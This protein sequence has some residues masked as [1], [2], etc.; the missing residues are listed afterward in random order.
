MHRSIWAVKRAHWRCWTVGRR[1]LR[2]ARVTPARFDLLQC[3]WSRGGTMMQRALQEALCVVRSTVSEALA[4]LEKLGL[5]VRGRRGRLGRS[6]TLTDAGQRAVD[7]GF[8]AQ[9]V[10]DDVIERALVAR[11]GKIRAL[12]R[13]CRRLRGAFGDPTPALLYDWLRYED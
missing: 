2:E 6:V 10:A 3:L 5:V 7:E 13:L 8:N 12:E 11:S 4:K 9:M 1:M